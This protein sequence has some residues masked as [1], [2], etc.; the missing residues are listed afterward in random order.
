MKSIE[1]DDEVY[2]KLGKLAEPFVETSPS[3]MIKTKF[4]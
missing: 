1:I 4:L 2:E 3:H